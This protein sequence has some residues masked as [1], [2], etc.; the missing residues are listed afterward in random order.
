MIY[1]YASVRAR[2]NKY[3]IINTTY[4]AITTKSSNV[5]ITRINIAIPITN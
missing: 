1:D 2:S 4:L 5:K 3:L